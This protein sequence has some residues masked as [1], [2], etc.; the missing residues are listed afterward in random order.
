MIPHCQFEKKI[1]MCK[2]PPTPFVTLVLHQG[3]SLTRPSPQRTYGSLVVTADLLGSSTSAGSRLKQ[4]TSQNSLVP[5]FGLIF[6]LRDVDTFLVN[7]IDTKLKFWSNMKFN[8]AGH[9]VVVNGVLVSS[10]LYFLGI[11]GRTKAGISRVTNR[12]CNFYL[13]GSP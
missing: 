7:K 10:L 4:E 13:C 12:I 3:Y 2:P 9:E 6:S 11:W 8:F 1:A 5:I